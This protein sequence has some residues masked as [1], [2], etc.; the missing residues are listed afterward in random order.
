MKY[1]VDLTEQEQ[2]PPPS[3]LNETELLIEELKAEFEILKEIF[4]ERKF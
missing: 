4:D 3:N 1:R 2:P